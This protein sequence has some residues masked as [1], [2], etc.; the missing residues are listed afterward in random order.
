MHEILSVS[1]CSS[2][3]DEILHHLKGIKKDSTQTLYTFDQT[4][5]RGQ[6]G[7]V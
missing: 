4:K 1:Q 5:G 2:T 7:N 6:Y 3:N